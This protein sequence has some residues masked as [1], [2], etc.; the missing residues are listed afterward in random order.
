MNEIRFEST[1]KFSDTAETLKNKLNKS[2]EKYQDECTFDNS[3]ASLVWIIRGGIEYFDCIDSDFLGDGNSSGIPSMKADHFANNFYRFYNAIEE[4]AKL[5]KVQF[6]KP[7]EIKLLNDIRTLIVHSGEQLCNIE[8]LELKGYKDSQLGRIFKNDD[9]EPLNFMRFKEHFSKYDYCIQVWN[10]RH[11]KSKQKQLAEAYYNQQNNDFYD[12]DI[13]VK[14]EDIRD[15]LLTMVENFLNI[16]EMQKLK[17]RKEHKLPDIKERVID[18][19]NHMIDFDKISNLISKD[20]RGGYL[21][22]NGLTY[23]DGF[24]L[25]KII[26]LC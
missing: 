22:E 4:L 13:Y 15:T 23:W 24:G 16:G 26:Q 14:A 11:N 3:E 21:I 10:D 2:I 1:A 19:N 18:L 25:Q 20:C 17:L 6:C 8:S 7:D 12:I 9:K 5:W